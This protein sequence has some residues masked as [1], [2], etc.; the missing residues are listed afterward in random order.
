MIKFQSEW[1]LLLETARANRLSIPETILLFAIR[2]VEA[3]PAKNE[4][5]K[6]NVQNTSLARQSDSMSLQIQKG[7]YLYQQYCKGKLEQ[8]PLEPNEQPVEFIVFLAQYLM[9]NEGVRKDGKWIK[10]VKEKMDEIDTF[11]DNKNGGNNVNN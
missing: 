7:E 8:F 3:G 5:N 1:P 2:E 4:F 10:A 6:Q 11:F 9:P